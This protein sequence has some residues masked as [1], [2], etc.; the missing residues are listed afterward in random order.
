MS[1]SVSD[2]TFWSKAFQQQKKI[3]ILT[4]TR[5]L[6]HNITLSSAITKLLCEDNYWSGQHKKKRWPIEWWWM[7]FLLHVA[8]GQW[9]ILH[10]LNHKFKRRL[11]PFTCCNEKQLWDWTVRI[12]V[13]ID[14]CSFTQA[15][16]T[17]RTQK[18]MWQWKRKERRHWLCL[19]RENYFLSE[20]G[21][22]LYGFILI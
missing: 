6:N 8:R 7:L 13:F 5:H 20:P 4:W 21:L 10:Q 9:P 12:P 14:C 18:V 19:H 11:M 17:E 22:V 15:T 3:I 2:L 1:I 16:R